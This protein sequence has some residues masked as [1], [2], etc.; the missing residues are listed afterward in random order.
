[1]IKYEHRRRRNRVRPVGPRVGTIRVLQ[2]WD[3]VEI[4]V[5]G[6]T[7][8]HTTLGQRIFKSGE[9]PVPKLTKRYEPRCT[10]L[11][12]VKVS[13]RLV[14]YQHVPPSISGST[15]QQ[16][17]CDKYLQPKNLDIGI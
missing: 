1:M 10:G 6:G 13:L 3:G 15:Y 11:A 14:T 9:P 5:E 17:A 12:V 4:G 2:G 7:R 16:P 8:T